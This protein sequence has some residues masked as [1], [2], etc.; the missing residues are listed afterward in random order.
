MSYFY[1]AACNGAWD[2]ILLVR[3]KSPLCSHSQGPDEAGCYECQRY[4]KMS[5]WQRIKLSLGVFIRRSR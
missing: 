5:S 1:N 3:V 4:L 2:D